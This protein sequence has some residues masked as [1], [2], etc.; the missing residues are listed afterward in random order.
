MRIQAIA[1]FTHLR[2][3]CRASEMGAG[4]RRSANFRRVRIE[5]ADRAEG[6][7]WP[8]IMRVRHIKPSKIVFHKRLL[9]AEK[10]Q[11]EPAARIAQRFANFAAKATAVFGKFSALPWN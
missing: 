5:V 8:A 6:I 4:E 3:S 1:N 7:T 11:C 10:W 2:L 9:A